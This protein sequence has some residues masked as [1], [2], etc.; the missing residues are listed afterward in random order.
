MLCWLLLV[1][2]VVLGFIFIMYILVIKGCVYSW[3]KLIYVYFYMVGWFVVVGVILIGILG[4]F[5][6]RM[7]YYLWFKKDNVRE[8][9]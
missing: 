3:F 2:W 9:I 7:V 4:V 8:E 5:Y 1:L 6:F